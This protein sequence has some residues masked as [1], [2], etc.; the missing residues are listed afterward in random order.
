MCLFLMKVFNPRPAPL[1]LL[2]Q[3]AWPTLSF[4]SIR[5]FSLRFDAD[6]SDL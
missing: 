6:V 5:L 3:R 1:I 2:K 4:D